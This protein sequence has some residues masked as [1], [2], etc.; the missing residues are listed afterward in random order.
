MLI[1]GNWKM[2]LSRAASVELTEA[3]VALHPEH[4]EGVEIAV[5][6]PSV[7][8]DAV[9]T[10]LGDS[11]IRLGG[12]DMYPAS[13]GAFT[14]EISSAMLLDLGCHYVIL[15]HSERRALMGETDEQVNRKTRAALESGLTPIVEILPSPSLRLAGLGR[16]LIAL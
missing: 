12:Q 11:T 3:L 13:N 9:G 10:A 1:A 14:G 16:L 7:Y 8:L 6:P 5:C 15:G 4:P 2:N